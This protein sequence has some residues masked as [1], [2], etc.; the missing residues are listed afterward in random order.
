[1]LHH[2]GL[3]KEWDSKQAFVAT[4]MQHT[5]EPDRDVATPTGTGNIPRKV[6][7]S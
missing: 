2:C 5:I 4:V 1:M 7:S 6:F 3:W